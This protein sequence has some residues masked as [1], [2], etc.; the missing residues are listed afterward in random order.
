MRVSIIIPVYKQADFVSEAI[1]SALAQT[2]VDRR[3]WWSMMARPTTA[4]RSYAGTDP[5]AT[6][7]HLPLLGAYGQRF[8][9]SRDAYPI[10]G[11]HGSAR[12][13]T[14]YPDLNFSPAFLDLPPA[15]IPGDHHSSP[16]GRSAGTE[17]TAT[18]PVPS[19]PAQGLP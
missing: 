14:L 5:A 8:V 12:G 9:T 2:Y 7:S 13:E 17:C 3:L 6:T 16:T 10:L 4:L 19:Q 1:E 18:E 11:T 15:T